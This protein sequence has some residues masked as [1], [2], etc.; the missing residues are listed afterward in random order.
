MSD[1][2][3]SQNSP[4]VG[5]GKPPREHRFSSEN[6]PKRQGRRRRR[7]AVALDISKSMLEALGAVVTVSKPDKQVK[8]TK[9]ALL[10]EKVVNSGIS[11]SANDALKLV[12]MIDDLKLADLAAQQESIESANEWESTYLRDELSSHQLLLSIERGT[13]E[14][15]SRKEARLTLAFSEMHQRCTCGAS[16]PMARVLAAIQHEDH[17]ELE[18]LFREFPEIRRTSLELDGEDGEEPDD[19]ACP[20]EPQGEP[21]IAC[22]IIKKS[23]D[24]SWRDDPDD[25]FYT[26]QLG[27]G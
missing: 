17:E 3:Q 26:G 5:Y 6:Q 27:N 9:A 20:Q 15:A 10:A 19:P 12:K 13:S 21:S 7:A 4:E 22:R 16:D 18:A 23:S 14:R 1:H 11:G 2:H 24:D 25:P 8:L